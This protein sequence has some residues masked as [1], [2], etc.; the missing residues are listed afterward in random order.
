MKVYVV[1]YVGGDTNTELS[2]VFA[3]KAD[4]RAWIATTGTP[5]AYAMVECE[6][7]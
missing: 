5:H 7:Q 6:V 1:F 2:A 3:T 4:A